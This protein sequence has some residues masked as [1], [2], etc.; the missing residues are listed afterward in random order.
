MGDRLPAAE[1]T[2]SGLLER[3]DVSHTGDLI[4]IQVGHT[5]PVIAADIANAWAEQY[6]GHVN[7][8]YGAAGLSNWE[9]LTE[10]ETSA[11]QG[12]EAAQSRLE[13]FVA[14]N[15]LATL[16]REIEARQALL[17]TYQS[18]R[19]ALQTQPVN[20]QLNSEQQVLAD[21]YQDLRRIERWLAD[22]HSL[23]SQ[24]EARSNSTAFN[25]GN[26]LALVALQNRIFD[27]S[28]P[29]DLQIDLTTGAVDPVPV[30][31]VD[32]IIAVLEERRDIT[33]AQIL[34]LRDG[35][36]AIAADELV[37]G[38]ENPLTVRIT[39]LNDE[40]LALQ[41]ELTAQQ[42]AENELR[43]SRDLSWETYQTLVRKQ[44]ETEIAI[45]TVGSEVR[46][47]SKAAVPEKPVS[48]GR[49]V[50]MAAAGFVALLATIFFIW[51][52]LWWQT[53]ESMKDETND[54][55]SMA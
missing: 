55:Q 37:I 24:V 54:E 48:R 22:A 26:L 4:L 18:A 36:L 28:V 27:S 10:Q 9:S 31:D 11:R 21:Y 50:S 2:L 20:L 46:V 13:A 42:A 43:Q 39:Q 32:A 38:P 14:N 33:N 29:V 5:D 23:R 17:D 7:S 30:A 34:A 35:L 41:A 49:S 40:I 16:Q 45:Q 15:R 3:V 51:A 1:Q 19:T 44:A 25:L 47:A 53:I 52:A 8:I 12:Y 6:S